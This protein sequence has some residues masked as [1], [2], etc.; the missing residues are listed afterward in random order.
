MDTLTHALSGALAARA[1]GPARAA[2]RVPPPRVRG[3]TGFWAAVFPDIDGLLR[4]V[5]ELM[6]L[7]WHRGVTHSFVLLPLWA[8]LVGV[9]L[10]LAYR[11]RYHPGWMIGIAG[12]AIAVH[13]LGDV[14]TAYGTS[15]FAPLSDFAP[16]P[17]WVLV[18]DPWLTLLLVLALLASHYRPRPAVA[19]AGIGAVGTFVLFQA[20]LNNHAAELGH[21]RAEA[22]NWPEARVRALAQPFS[23]FNRMVIVERDGE[24]ERARVN[25]MRRYAPRVD[26]RHWRVW[27]LHR[28]YRPLT[29][30]TWER[31]RLLP[32]RPAETRETAQTAWTS[33]ALA[34][35]R[36]FAHHPV[37]YR[38]DQERG[39]TCIWF[40]DLRY[41]YQPLP[42]PFRFG[43]CRE[44]D[45]AD[46]VLHELGW[47]DA[48][49][50]A[51]PSI[52]SPS[53]RPGR[54]LPGLRTSTRD[55]DSTPRGH[56]YP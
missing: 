35:F 33:A 27:Q 30:P 31:F 46:W 9:A 55:I 53:S 47:Y 28:S 36:R 7:E 39:S 29:A 42:A 1:V 38:I 32:Q 12:L 8:L 26:S 5:D 40:T 34:P 45:D 21:Q 17:A 16:A 22:L 43:A 18:I 6:Y 2:G 25:L 3:W 41:W 24:Y 15:I 48:H 20:L 50:P 44:R 11:R 19:L 4:F 52:G 54:T 37:L 13:I 49:D 10:H 56:R 51:R 23:P 14:I